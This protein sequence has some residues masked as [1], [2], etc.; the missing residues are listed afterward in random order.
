VG[1]C[2]W[3]TQPAM[4]GAPLGHAASATASAAEAAGPLPPAPLPVAKH[5]SSSRQGNGLGPDDTTA[6][7]GVV[8]ET[9]SPADSPST[10][11]ELSRRRMARPSR[12]SPQR[13]SPD[14]NPD[15]PMEMDGEPLPAAVA[16]AAAGVAAAASAV[17]AAA[18]GEA[19]PAAAAAE[20]D[21]ADDARSGWYG[22]C[23]I[24]LRKGPKYAGKVLREHVERSVRMGEP[25]SDSLLLY[26]LSHFFTK[27]QACQLGNICVSDWCLH[28]LCGGEPSQTF[29]RQFKQRVGSAPT[30]TGSATRAGALAVCGRYL[31][32]GEFVYSCRTCAVSCSNVVCPTC[33]HAGN[34][35]EGHDYVMQVTAGGTCDCGDSGWRSFGVCNKHA[36]ARVIE[37]QSRMERAAQEE[38]GRL[39]CS[40]EYVQQTALRFRLRALLFSVV[41]YVCSSVAQ[42][43]AH[44][45]PVH[46]RRFASVVKVN[47]QKCPPLADRRVVLYRC[48]P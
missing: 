28:L 13:D 27:A 47:R 23:E 21:D 30:A 46:Q 5:R 24:L 2:A 42:L 20:S 19:E 37:E 16:T 45:D 38:A 31:A 33:F 29:L 36:Q 43:G 32:E 48:L 14:G 18:G 11:A 41:S 10:E 4:D 26:F 9:A 6:A 7:A 40:E 12:H 35:H 44:P 8:G 39:A 3:L 15:T 17:D 1:T 34:K 25:L 22:L